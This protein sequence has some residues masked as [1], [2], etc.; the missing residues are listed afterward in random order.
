MNARSASKVDGPMPFTFISASS[1]A[2][3]P[4]CVRY[5][6]MRSAIA[7][8]TLGNASS[9]AALAVL[10]FTS[11]PALPLDAGTPTTPLF[12][13]AVGL[14][15]GVLPGATSPALATLAVLAG[16]AQSATCS[17]APFASGAAN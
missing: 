5:S 13:S 11:A 15:A 3:G 7:G 16:G 14:L 12:A 9:W 6:I 1:V 10:M 4:C 2:K 17:C 8:P